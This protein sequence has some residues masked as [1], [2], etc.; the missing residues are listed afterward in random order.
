MYSFM[1]LCFCMCTH[2][3]RY[4]TCLD[5][6]LAAFGVECYVAALNAAACHSRSVKYTR[7]CRAFPPQG[8]FQVWG[9]E[10]RVR[11]KVSH[12]YIYGLYEYAHLHNMLES[13][14]VWAGVGVRTLCFVRMLSP[15]HRERWPACVYIYIS[16]C[17]YI[18]M[19]MYM[20]S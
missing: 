4:F 9:I 14:S 15:F 13:V 12:T 18:Y 1:Y 16:I 3:Y 7:V 6:W 20:R 17:M 19:H 10:P 8:K 5:L 11:T 2:R